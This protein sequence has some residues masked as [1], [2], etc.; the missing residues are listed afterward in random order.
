MSAEDVNR[1]TVGR[2]LG[3]I[4]LLWLASY[5]LGIPFKFSLAI[6]L[7]AISAVLFLDWDRRRHGRGRP[8]AYGSSGYGTLGGSGVPVSDFMYF[9]YGHNDKPQDS[10]VVCYE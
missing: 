4:V 2:S 3:G 5:A 8:G 1:S 6:A 7:L 10:C 9:V